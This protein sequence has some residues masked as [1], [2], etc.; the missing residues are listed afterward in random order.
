[1]IYLTII[2]GLELVVIGCLV[3]AL[4]R[5]RDAT[6]KLLASFAAQAEQERARLVAAIQRPDV[7]QHLAKPLRRRTA[8]EIEA[9]H[10]RQ[11]ELASVGTVTHA[12]PHAAD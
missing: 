5:E 3:L 7:V 11:R 9:E 12:R 8:E 10:R 6:T 2:A 1:M 4:L